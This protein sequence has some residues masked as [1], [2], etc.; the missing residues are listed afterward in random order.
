MENNLIQENALNKANAKTKMDVI[1]K[2]IFAFLAFV[3]ASVIIFIVAF[4]LFKGIEPFVKTYP[5]GGKQDIGL[6]F[7]NERWTYDGTG[8][9]SF[10]ALATMY[11]SSL[12]LIVSVPTSI[13][14]A[15]FIVKIC[16][17]A[18]KE[19]IKTAVQILASIPSVIFGLFEMGVINPLVKNFAN[20]M[21][22]QT[23]GGNSV[24]SGVFVLAF[25]SIPTITLVSITAMEA[26]D[27]NLYKASLAL[28]ASTEQTNYKITFKAAQSGV[29]AGIILGIGRALGEA[30]EI[31]M[32]IGNGGSGFDFVNPFNIYATLTTKMLTGIGE[33]SG[34]GYDVR[35]SL[36]VVL[37][38]IIIITK[39][40]L[41]FIKD[42]MTRIEPRK[43][44]DWL[45]P[46]RHL[47]VYY[48]AYKN[49]N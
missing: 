26:V 48:E 15:L 33:A 6:F 19:I 32:V 17:K 7:T 1:V 36:G 31:Q 42:E 2:S 21:G 35:F 28:G 47:K 13:F 16:P 12:S 43:K 49:E 11:V 38:I 9:M 44:I 18:F 24:L 37:M 23:F 5:S 4:V 22:T 3:Y 8:G 30:T 20:A 14:T 46:F 10:L 34:L 45:K 40:L 29:F 27:N 25:M 41:N 39:V